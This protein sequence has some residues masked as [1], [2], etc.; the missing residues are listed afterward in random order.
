MFIF[1]ARLSA[2]AIVAGTRAQGTFGG[3]SDYFHF[4]HYLIILTS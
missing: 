4:Y 2:V 1:E 3:V